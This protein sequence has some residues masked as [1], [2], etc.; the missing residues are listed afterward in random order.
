M[1][2]LLALGNLQV[3]VMVYAD[4]PTRVLCFSDEPTTHMVEAEQ[5]ILDLAARLK[6]V[7]QI[8]FLVRWALSSLESAMFDL[9]GHEQGEVA[10]F[11]L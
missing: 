4:G 7:I 9:V 1:T 6:Q 3:Y 8:F 11:C 10:K 5:S 2:R